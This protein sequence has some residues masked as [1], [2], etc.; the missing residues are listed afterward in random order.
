[1]SPTVDGQAQRDHKTELQELCARTGR[2]SPQYVLSSIGPDHAKVF[3]ADVWSMVDSV[4]TGE[5]GSKKS[6]EQV[7]AA[8]AC[9]ALS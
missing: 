1:M 9:V 6:A 5:G 3:T 8:A 7:A 4:G 2:S